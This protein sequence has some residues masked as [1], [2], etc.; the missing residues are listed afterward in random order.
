MDIMS[1][2]RGSLRHFV[3]RGKLLVP[4][5]IPILG[6]DFLILKSERETGLEPATTRL[7]SKYSTTELLPQ[8]QTLLIESNSAAAYLGI[9]IVLSANTSGFPLGSLPKLFA[10]EIIA[11]LEPSPYI[12]SAIVNKVSPCATLYVV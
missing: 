8:R 9:L 6:L 11:H 12:F 3:P 10:F 1:G 5:H 2:K 4:S 7:G